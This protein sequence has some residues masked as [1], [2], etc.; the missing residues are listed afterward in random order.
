[1]DCGRR[2]GRRAR[3]GFTLIE[4]LTSISIIG[5][6][7]ALTIPA[8]QAAREAA[9]RAQCVNNLKQIGLAMHNY[10]SV[11]RMFPPGMAGH[12]YSY[13][14]MILPFFD[15]ANVF[16]GVN[17]SVPPTQFAPGRP[18]FT[19]FWAG[20]GLFVCPSDAAYSGAG[21]PAS[22]PGNSGTGAAS[23]G[24]DGVILAS[25]RG[26]RIADITDGTS[27]TAAVCERLVYALQYDVGPDWADPARHA[28]FL[29]NCRDGKGPGET[30]ATGYNWMEGSL[31]DGLYNHALNINGN[32]CPQG[33][34][35]GYGAWSAGSRHPGGSNVL[36]ADG[37]VDFGRSGMEVEAWRARGSR[38]GGDPAGDL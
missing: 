9:R 33:S 3:R 22:Y 32:T 6:L 7:L 1:M 2:H 35:D 15:G 38:S 21:R 28:V 17:F 30:I 16:N 4:L 11:H 12:G 5:L 20:S 25:A 23:L 37:H 27:T 34:G 14:S 13:M 36:H 26:V 29:A 8:V 10:E 18:N 24:K 19:S 31:T